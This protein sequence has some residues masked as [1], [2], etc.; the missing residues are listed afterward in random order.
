MRVLSRVTDKQLDTG[1][2][3]STVQTA[4]GPMTYKLSL[5]DMTRGWGWGPAPIS[6]PGPLAMDQM[7][8]NLH[9]MADKQGLDSP[10]EIRDMMKQFTGKRV[11]RQSGHTPLELAQDMVFNAY[12]QVGRRRIGLAKQALKVC[13]DCADAYV[14][15]AEETGD[16]DRQIE[17]Y[18]KGMQAGERALGPTTFERDAGHFWGI[19]ETRPYMRAR[20]GLARCLEFEDRTDEAIEH[21]RELLRLNP[22]DNQSVR[23]MLGICL[24]NQERDREVIELCERYPD[25]FLA[26]PL[27][28]RALAQFRLT[29]D[30]PA[31]RTALHRAVKANPYVAELL[32]EEDEPP[33]YL[34]EAYSPGSE[35]E[36]A[37]CF[38][39]IDEAW[40]DT[41]NAIY[42]LRANRGNPE[43]PDTPEKKYKKRKKHSR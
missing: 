8:T 20:L 16:P 35:E 2:W 5:P 13:P 43:S 21:Y 12:E 27:Y 14:L 29:G 23:E 9:R 34:P 38:D 7:L 6:M 3:Q 4:L 39:E 18:T 24:L 37:I 1:R 33:I 19:L 25:D 30:S 31:A 40:L 15:L 10:E 26:L 22:N 11:P 41:P 28:V 17:L 36:A 32:L 42:W